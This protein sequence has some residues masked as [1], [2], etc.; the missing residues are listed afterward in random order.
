MSKLALQYGISDVGLAKVCKRYKIPRPPRGYWAKR[1]ASQAVKKVPLQRFAGMDGDVAVRMQGWDISEAVVKSATEAVE[2]TQVS[3]PSAALSGPVD[4]LVSLA[5]DQLRAATPDHD[6]LVCTD[7]ATALDIRVSPLLIDRSLEV[8]EGFVKRWVMQ[9]GS[10]QVGA[11]DHHGRRATA[12]VMGSDRLYVQIVESINESK[13]ITDPARRRGCLALHIGGDEHRQFRRRW[14][15]TKS[16]RIEKTFKPL[17]ETLL[18][19]LGLKKSDRLD[20]ECRVRQKQAVQARRKVGA[21]SDDREFYWRQELDQ[22]ADRWHRAQ[23]IREYLKAL[24]AAISEKKLHFQD[25][26]AFQRWFDWAQNYVDAIDP[27]IRAK[28]PAEIAPEPTNTLVGDLDVTSH[29]QPV[30]M[31]LGIANT[32]D[33]VKVGDAQVRTA[34]QGK[35]ADVWDEI[36]RVLE[37]LGYDVANRKSLSTWW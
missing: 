21:R 22:E 23:R 2:M 33:L 20:E 16:Q 32:D 15:D 18:L 30:L 36:T 13:A 25:E 17:I 3:L 34:C 35:V 28:L 11:A 10:I 9:N 26:K 27:T 4:P 8:F 19:V 37:G 29:T 31:R 7:P 6:G 12:V 5:G 1:Q 24:Q 14:A